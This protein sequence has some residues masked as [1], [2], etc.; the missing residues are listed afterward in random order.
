MKIFG[1]TQYV[2]LEEREQPWYQL[3]V[4]NQW[5]F[6]SKAVCYDYSRETLIS[7]CLKKNTKTSE[8]SYKSEIIENLNSEMQ[9]EV[10][11]MGYKLM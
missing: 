4:I 1:S 6:K 3:E 7:Y 9:R 2:N 10:I 11:K 8:N 5:D